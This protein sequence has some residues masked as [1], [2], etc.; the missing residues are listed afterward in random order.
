[1]CPLQPT[2]QPSSCKIAVGLPVNHCSIIIILLLPPLYS[3][4]LLQ[5]LPVT[6]PK[7]SLFFVQLV[8]Q[9]HF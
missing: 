7:K 1:L 3:S 2:R 9:D 8:N 5:L 4:S 6:I